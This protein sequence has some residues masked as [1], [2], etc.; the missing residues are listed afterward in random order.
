MFDTIGLP[1][2]LTELIDANVARLGAPARRVLEVSAVIGG[3]IELGVVARTCGLPEPDLQTAIEVVRQA[4]V[5]VESSTDRAALRFDHPL[6]R[7][8]LLHGLGAARRAQLHQRVAEAIEAYHH[9]DVDRFSAD[10][11]HHLAAAANVGSARDAIDS[12][13]VPANARRQSARTTRPCTG[14]RMRSDSRRTAATTS[15]P[16]PASSPRWARRRTRRRRGA[17]HTVLLEAVTA[18]R[19]AGS[20]ERFTQAVLRLG[21]VLVDEGNEG[22]AVDQR[23]VSLL[24][25]SLATLPESSPLRAKVLV[26]LATELHFAGDRDHCLAL[27]ADAEAIARHADDT[28]A[29]A[30]VFSRGTTRSTARPTC[31]SV[32]RLVAEIQALR[33]VARPQHRWLRDYL[34]IGDST[35]SKPPPRTSNARS[36][37]PASRAIGTTPPSGGQRRPRCAATS[38]SPRRPRTKPPRSDVPRRAG[39]LGVAAVWAAQIFAVR[40]FD[41]RLAELCE[42]VDAT[43][44]AAPTRPIWRAA[45][46]F[47]HLELRRPERAETHFRCLRTAGILESAPDDRPAVDAGDAAR[48]WRRRSVRSPTRASFAVRFGRTASRSLCSEPPRH[49]CVRPD[50]VPT[51]NA[52]GAPRSYGRRPHCS[53]R[54][55]TR[56]RRSADAVARPDPAIAERVEQLERVTSS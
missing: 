36:Q 41:G 49:Q 23:L 54:P 18:A 53:C 12:R 30:A 33:T 7:E 39:P 51:R 1:R 26:R 52:R 42:L 2:G 16:S 14:S 20:A 3:S 9:D 31:R 43:A 37:R 10:L 24:E 22:G 8:V 34:E 27:C 17:A 6:V 32:S 44:D 5:L 28:D 15:T 13:F 11:A 45:A 29:L 4:G 25:E 47:M 55:S 21:G 38:T 48:G 50:D 40:L 19:A 35:Q 56:Q 46:A